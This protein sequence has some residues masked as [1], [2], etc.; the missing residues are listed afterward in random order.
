VTGERLKGLVEQWVGQ[1][2]VGHQGTSI[3]L[4][5]PTRPKFVYDALLVNACNAET[6]P[7]RQT[8]LLWLGGRVLELGRASWGEL[9]FS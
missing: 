7:T 4:P 9:W 2:N 3:A 1:Q 8:P 5:G 6:G